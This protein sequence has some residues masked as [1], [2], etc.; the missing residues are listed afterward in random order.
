MR[1]CLPVAK[2]EHQR[3]VLSAAATSGDRRFFLGTDSASHLIRDKET[4]SGCAG[5][6]TAPVALELYAQVFEEEGTLDR[7]E[8]FA[9]LN[10]ARFYGLPPSAETITLVQSLW[11]TP[12]TIA[13]GNKDRVQV[14]CPDGVVRWRLF[15]SPA[16]NN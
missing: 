11:Q 2:R 15:A 1:Y 9:S 7:L 3:L 8:A 14:F 13:V 12:E 5:I 6:F 4:A 16:E 10:G